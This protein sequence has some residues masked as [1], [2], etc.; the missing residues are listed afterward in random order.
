MA[1]VMLAS[2]PLGVTLPLTLICACIGIYITSRLAVELTRKHDGTTP[3]ETPNG[4][5]GQQERKRAIN[6]VKDLDRIAEMLRRDLATH[7]RSFERFKEYVDR[8]DGVQLDEDQLTL[9]TEAREVLKQTNQLGV[10]ITKAFEEIHQKA[11]DLVT[12]AGISNDSMSEVQ[13]R[14]SLNATLKRMFAM[15]TRY[16]IPF[17]LVML[18]AD[19]ADTMNEGNGDDGFGIEEV[20]RLIGRAVRETDVVARYGDDFFVVMLPFAHL[21]SAAT[22]AERL[23]EMMQHELQIAIRAGVA[24]A[25]DTDDVPNLLRRAVEALEGAVESGENLVFFHDGEFAQSSRDLDLDF[26]PVPPTVAAN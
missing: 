1:I 3:K 18:K 17:S 19:R 4:T 6:V 12:L 2:L 26:P 20:V 13:D 7:D 8:L 24:T 25:E 23:R 5:P 9:T 14:K 22:F 16:Q 21:Q 11:A 10:Q 15:R